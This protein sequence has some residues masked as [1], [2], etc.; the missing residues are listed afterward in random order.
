VTDDARPLLTPV[1]LYLL[2]A[3]AEGPSYGYAI[4]KRV[5]EQSSGAVRPDIGALYRVLGKLS[6]ADW[7][8]EADPPRQAPDVYPGRARR[9]YRLTS[10]GRAA[11]R[12][13]LSRLRAVVELGARHHLV[14]GLRR[15]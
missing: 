5:E 3:L 8:E 9:Y 14:A 10:D 2:L 11:L 1:E 15:S 4:M 6:V 13:E 12:S 7:V